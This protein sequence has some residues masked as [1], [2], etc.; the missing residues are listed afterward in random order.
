MNI[1][2]AIKAVSKNRH[3]YFPIG[4]WV[5]GDEIVVRTKPL[6]DTNGFASPC[7]FVVNSD[8]TVRGTTPME[9]DL[10]QKTMK[11]IF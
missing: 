5:F 8:G 11:K 3:G 1:K 2:D 10:S 6:Y 4:Y 7:I 9:Y